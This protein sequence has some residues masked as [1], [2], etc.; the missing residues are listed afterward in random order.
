MEV[1]QVNGE[2][3]IGN[4]ESAMVSKFPGLVIRKTANVKR[5]INTAV[6]Y[7]QIQ[8]HATPYTVT[9]IRNLQPETLT[10]EP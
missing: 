3:A 4:R 5:E 6:S 1:L 9:V 7:K 10:R 2:S 8:F